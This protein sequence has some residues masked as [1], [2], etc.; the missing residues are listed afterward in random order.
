MRYFRPGGKKSVQL[1][2]AF[3][4]LTLIPFAGTLVHAAIENC[5]SCEIAAQQRLL[6]RH[7][8][9]LTPTAN[10]SVDLGW[11]I[12]NIVN[13]PTI[14]PR[15]Q[16]TGQDDSSSPISFWTSMTDYA[17]QMKLP[18][19][20]KSWWNGQGELPGGFVR[21]WS[22]P[23]SNF[24]PS[25]ITPYYTTSQGPLNIQTAPWN[26]SPFVQTQSPGG[27]FGNLPIYPNT[28]MSIVPNAIQSGDGSV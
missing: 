27:L 15:A 24:D 9:V 20:S 21:P 19:G 28:P 2:W 26:L 8:N 3:L 11:N 12:A 17:S 10:A 14:Q 5:P 6:D 23:K 22:F 7:Q 1:N 13:R 16:Y 4:S 25:F 18:A